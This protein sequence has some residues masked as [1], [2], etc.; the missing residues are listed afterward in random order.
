MLFN[1]KWSIAFVTSIALYALG[2]KS[3]F[4]YTTQTLT[5]WKGDSEDLTGHGV[6]SSASLC[7]AFGICLVCHVVPISAQSTS[8]TETSRFETHAPVLQNIS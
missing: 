2:F 5:Q 4:A 8:V 7:D 3:R 6:Y 1:L